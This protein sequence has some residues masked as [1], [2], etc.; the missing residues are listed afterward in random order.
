[1]SEEKIKS[2]SLSTE[3]GNEADKK[4]DDVI[5]PV[6]DSAVTPVADSAVPVAEN[7]N[8]VKA[9]EVPGGR[10]KNKLCSCCSA[11]VCPTLMGYACFPILLGQIIERLKYAPSS[12]GDGTK[13]LPVCKIFTIL[14]FLVIIIEII[15]IATGTTDYSTGVTSTEYGNIYYEM[16]NSYADAPL[17]HQ[18]LVWLLAVWAWFIFIV[19]CCTRMKMRK[20]YQLE[21]LCCGDN[22]CDDCMTTWCC[23]CCS[24]IQMARQ[25]HD[26]DTYEYHM[27][28]RTGLGPGAP[29]IV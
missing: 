15:V 9:F 28:S 24:T 12:S 20:Q 16:D 21:P 14:F 29:E 3:G 26:E 7:V 23:N 22:C 5:I 27:M 17:Y 2:S 19:S 10:W 8:E 1:M 18:I 4:D 11:C 13:S 6:A 25:T